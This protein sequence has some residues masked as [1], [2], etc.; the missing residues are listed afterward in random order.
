MLVMLVEP[1]VLVTL[2]EPVVLVTPNEPV[3]LLLEPV[4]VEP[5]VDEEVELDFVHSALRECV[6]FLSPHPLPG[7]VPPFAKAGP[8]PPIA[9]NAPTIGTA[10]AAERATCVRVR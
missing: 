1:V 10:T 4:E 3:V 5:L 8:T 2:I 7:N 9:A 6:W